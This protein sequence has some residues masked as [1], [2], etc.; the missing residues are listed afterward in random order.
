MEEAF[1]E[2]KSRLTWLNVGDLDTAYFHRVTKAKHARNC[3]LY[4][5]GDKLTKTGKIQNESVSFFKNLSGS[6]NREVHGE[7][8]QYFS[9]LLERKLFRGIRILSHF[10]TFPRRYEENSILT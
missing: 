5:N 8:F 2:Q 10:P 6:E 3:S 9:K 4:N 1:F 7:S